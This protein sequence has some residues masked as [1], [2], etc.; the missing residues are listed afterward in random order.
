M[1]DVVREYVYVM[2]IRNKK[3]I[4]LILLNRKRIRKIKIKEMNYFFIL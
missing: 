2:L 3:I 4:D 1:E